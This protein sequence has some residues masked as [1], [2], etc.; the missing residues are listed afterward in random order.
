MKGQGHLQVQLD[1]LD[2][3]GIAGDQGWCPEA[4]HLAGGEVLNPDVDRGTHIRADPHR[5][6]GRPVHRHDGHQAQ[7]QGDRQHERAGLE[8]VAN[9]ALHHAV[10]DDVGVQIGQE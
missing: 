10:V 1:L 2:V 4:V 7:H 5:H 9:A 6:P 3:V 8:D